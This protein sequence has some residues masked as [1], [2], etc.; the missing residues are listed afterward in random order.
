MVSRIWSAV[1]VHTNGRGWRFQVSI[2]DSQAECLPAAVVQLLVESE[3]LPQSVERLLVAPQPLVDL[4]DVA[5]ADGQ[6]KAVTQ[7]P[8]DGQAL[9]MAGQRLLETPLPLIDDAEVVQARALTEV[10]PA[11]GRAG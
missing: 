10:Y 8:L 1:L 9:L 2:Q 11:A 4:A 6:A 7:L 3:A 5:E